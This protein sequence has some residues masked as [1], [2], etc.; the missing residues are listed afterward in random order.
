MLSGRFERSLEVFYRD[1]TAA[2]SVPAR[3]GVECA[4][5]PGSELMVTGAGSGRTEETPI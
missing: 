1:A 3:P 5:A 2:A 4:P